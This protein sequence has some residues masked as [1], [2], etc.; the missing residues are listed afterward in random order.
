MLEVLRSGMLAMGERTLA[1]EAAWAANC[2]VR[3]AVFM[4][5]ATVALQALLEALGLVPG[6]EVITVSFS[7]N[8]TASAVIRAGAKPV[9]V[10]V[11]E[12]DFNIDP[13]LVESAITPRTRAIMPVHLYGLTADM[14]PLA[15]LAERYGLTLVEDAAQ[16]IGA[17]YH[18]RSAGQLGV[19]AVFSLYATK[20]VTAGEGGMVTTDDDRLADRLRI[21][22]NHG[23]RSRYEHVALGSNLKP[24]DI[25]AAIALAQLAELDRRTEKRRR[26]ATRLSD[27]LDGH[28]VPIVP[29]GR[30]HAWHQYTLR[31]PGRRDRVAS[32][33]RERGIG[34]EIYYPVP[35]HRQPYLRRYLP[36]AADVVLPVTDRLAA[37]VL[38]IPVRSN[39]TEDELDTVIRAVRELASPV[40]GPQA[41]SG[42]TSP[43]G[44]A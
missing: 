13:E 15:S 43:A 5:N 2:G 28:L 25:G 32:A 31:I 19:A 23:M 21:L 38:S 30:D 26:N 1:L 37:E 34:A 41:G 6:D 9:F 42:T 4:A 24:T 12:S 20:N 27:G 8:A 29:A 39:L 7:F 44:V 3:H 36:G 14:D 40:S 18:G 17:R 10:D 33:L 22:R 11:T 16:A 35:I